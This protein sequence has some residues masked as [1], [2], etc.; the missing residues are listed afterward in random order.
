MIGVIVGEILGS[1][2]GM[3]ALINHAYGLLRTADYVALVLVTLVMVVGSDVLASLL[4]RRAQPVDRNEGQS[5]SSSLTVIVGLGAWEADRTDGLGRPALRPGAERRSR[6]ALV[7]DRRAALAGLADTLGK[8]AVAY[9]LS[10][11]L[12]VC[13]RASPSARCGSL[14]DVLS[15]YVI[16]LYGMPKILVLP[17]IVL[18]ARL[19]HR[20]RRSSTAR[21]TASFRSWSWSWAPCATSTG[22]S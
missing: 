12:G 18:L 17:W 10:V 2:A 13:A 1:K 14:R 15:P 11:V 16:A 3:G 21:S 22:R 6:A 7:T 8:T 5:S 19:R 4:E 20:P 9:V